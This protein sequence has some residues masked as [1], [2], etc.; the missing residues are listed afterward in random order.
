MAEGS[1]VPTYHNYINGQWVESGSGRTY[2]ITNPADTNTV[3]GNFQMSV[4]DDANRAIDAAPRCPSRLVVHA[5][6]STSVHPLPA[7]WR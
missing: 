6:P 5:C 2:T 4:V 1:R 7:P 3:L